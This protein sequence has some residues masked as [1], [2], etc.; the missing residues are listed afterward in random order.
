MLGSQTVTTFSEIN[1]KQNYKIYFSSRKKN[2]NKIFFDVFKSK[3]YENLKNLNPDYIINCIGLIKPKMTSNL[4]KSSIKFFEINSILPMYL[5]DNFNKSKIINFSSD[6]VFDGAKG[7][8][9]ENEKASSIDI[10]GISKNLGEVKNKNVMNIRCSIVGFEKETSYSLLSWFLKKNSKK[11]NGYKD[12]Y[13]NGIT[14]YALS[15]ICVGIIQSNIFKNG[16]FHIFSKNKISK[17]ELLCLFNKYLKKKKIEIKPVKSGNPIDMTLS[18]KHKKYI[19]KLWKSSGYESIPS[20]EK[21]I[22]ELI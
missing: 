2:N 18:S 20:I 9:L 22:K 10:Y 19:L 12:Q 6:G 16:L 5:A 4:S 3:T 14:T 7:S 17:Y 11:I 21:L 15:K 8:Y 13:W 1:K